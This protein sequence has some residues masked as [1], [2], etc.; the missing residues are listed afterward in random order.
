MRP[1]CIAVE[2]HI[3]ARKTFD[4]L[5]KIMVD[6]LCGSCNRI[7]LKKKKRKKRHVSFMPLSSVTGSL[8]NDL[9]QVGIPIS[10]ECA[11]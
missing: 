5:Q 7:L 10:K 9:E 3:W 1:A 2:R 11:L 4:W 6:V 8:A